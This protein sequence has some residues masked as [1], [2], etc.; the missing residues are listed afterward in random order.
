VVN[1]KVVP[2]PPGKQSTVTIQARD[3]NG[4]FDTV[5]VDTTKSDP[6]PTI[7]I[8]QPSPEQPK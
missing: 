6:S 1:G 4:Q 3:L 7:E 2:V 8:Q 5:Y